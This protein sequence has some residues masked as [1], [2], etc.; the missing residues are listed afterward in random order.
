MTSR[1]HRGLRGHGRWLGIVLASLTVGYMSQLSP[2]Y[3]KLFHPDQPLK[4]LEKE[5]IETS[6]EGGACASR[7]RFKGLGNTQFG[8][9]LILGRVW[10]SFELICAENS[11]YS[12]PFS[13]GFGARKEK[14][15]FRLL[16]ATVLRS[17][18]DGHFDAVVHFPLEQRKNGFLDSIYAISSDEYAIGLARFNDLINSDLQIYSFQLALV[19]FFFS[20][21]I[22]FIALD[23]SAR[24][25]TSLALLLCIGAS[26]QT[27]LIEALLPFS[28]ILMMNLYVA[29][30]TS[31][32]YCTYSVQ[33]FLG[34]SGKKSRRSYFFASFIVFISIF[35]FTGAIIS[36]WIYF[37]IAFGA[38]STAYSLF[39]KNPKAVLISISMLVAGLEFYGL[40]GLPNSFFVPVL[41]ALLLFEENVQALRSYLKINR[42]LKLS[43]AEMPGGSGGNAHSHSAGALIKYFQRQFRIGKVTVLNLTDSETIQVEQYTSTGVRPRKILLRELP[44]IFAHV[45]TTGNALVHIHSSSKLIASLRR[46][47]QPQTSGGFQSDYFTVLP[48]NMGKETIG[49]I[50]IT[51]YD[52][53]QFSSSLY[54]STFL[55]CLDIIKG[56]LV[57]RLLMHPKTETLNSITRLGS[58]VTAIGKAGVPTVAALVD[59]CGEVLHREFG[60]RILSATL[61]S[62]DHLLTVGAV[63][64][65]DSEV[66]SQVKSGKIYAHEDN[67]QGPIALA[68]HEKKPVIVPNT[69]WLEGVVHPNTVKFFKAHGTRSAAF[70][71]I[72]GPEGQ[73][74]A[75]YWI[76]G[77]RGNEISYSDRELFI[78]FMNLVGEQLKLMISNSRLEMS[79]QSLGQF[80]PEHLV[81]DFLQGKEVRED[82][83]GFLMMFDLKGSTRLAHAL[84]NQEFHEAVSEFK[85]QVES[86]LA[87]KGWV[88]RQFVWDGFEFTRT[89][90]EKRLEKISVAE[91]QELLEPVFFEWKAGLKAKRGDLPEIEA[92]SYR[93]CFTYGDISRGIVVEGATQKWTFVGNA[94]AVVSKVEQA[95]KHLPGKVFGD[96]TIL[97]RSRDQWFELHSTPQGLLVYGLVEAAQVQEEGAA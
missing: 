79:H 44:P 95:A 32:S 81:T 11:V 8:Q 96:A 93:M 33:Y 23:E 89:S 52:N 42:L 74:M 43:R 20:L 2:Y 3:L 45:I 34:A 97:K 12:V 83:H 28:T 39:N 86:V 48:I 60:W 50:S 19:V 10:N 65:F 76:E 58:E 82:D 36:T 31:G 55:F 15:A 13:G 71:P 64:S 62:A 49:A 78:S 18:V 61:Q 72:L 75:V 70:V 30:V 4:V 54:S 92:L 77:L 21:L 40:K 41:I 80:I 67:K 53:E 6:C 46:T 1:L 27:G 9:S 85:N 7:Y 14:V 35:I 57:E 22:K 47:N 37:F 56:L 26:T 87:P 94:I 88:L 38:I 73:A 51:E 24:D 66:E 69:Q 17:C 91:W 16:P 63:Y 90:P 68:V 29:A 59:A 5:L 25:R 84:G